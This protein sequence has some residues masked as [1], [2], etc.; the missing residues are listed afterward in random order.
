MIVFQYNLITQFAKLLFKV[1]INVYIFSLI[2]L[3]ALLISDLIYNYERLKII[4]KS[5]Q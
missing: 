5:Y 1:E 2:Q 3:F 4:W